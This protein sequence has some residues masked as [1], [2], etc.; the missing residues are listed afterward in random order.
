MESAVGHKVFGLEE[1]HGVVASIEPALDVGAVIGDSGAEA[2]RGFHD[3][4][5]DMALEEAGNGYA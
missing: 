4:E 5:R 3:V 2:D 1:L